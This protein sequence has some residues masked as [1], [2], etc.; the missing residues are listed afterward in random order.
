M[1]VS[2]ILFYLGVLLIVA[3]MMFPFA[4]GVILSFKDN[5]GIFNAPTALPTEWD[6]GKY[7][8]TFKIAHLD[9][10]FR[11]SFIVAS[12]TTIGALFVNFLSSFAIARLHHRHAA[13]GDFFYYLFLAA[14]AV[15][16]FALLYPLYMIALALKPLGLGIDSIM[17]L[18]WPYI[19]IMI[20]FNT[21][22]L[23]GGLKSIPLEME[24]AALMDGCSL[25][26][27]LFKVELP[28]IMPVFM[29]LL[30]LNFLHAWNEFTLASIILNSMKKLTI[31]LAAYF[32]RDQYSMD[33][34]AVIR[35][36]NI[37]LVPQ[38]IFFYIFQRKIIE[39]MATSGLKV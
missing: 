5:F 13:M 34:G 9:W 25:L 33:Y 1:K 10:L 16:I 30:I 37:V 8:E 29:T 35:A 24:E 38:L 12:V 27:M 6:F 31:P 20:P 36:V 7:I 2:R 11:N 4:W 3:V 18:P 19:A 14:T 28:L 17:G 21:L 22:V 39:G 15:P 23:V 26:R 32:F